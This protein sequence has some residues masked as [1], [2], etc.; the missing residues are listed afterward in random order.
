MSSVDVSREHARLRRDAATGQF[1]LVD[2]STL[3]TTLNNRHVP[4][5]YEEVEGVRR[6]T[7]AETPLPDRARIGL[8]DTV[9]LEFTV[10]GSGV[11]ASRTPTASDPS[12]ALDK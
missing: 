7:G 1:F 6:A 3:G 5:G 8:A 4:S 10:M 11:I 12:G 2:L 9:F